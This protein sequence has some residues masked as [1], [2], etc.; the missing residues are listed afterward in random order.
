MSEHN[1]LLLY[2]HDT[3]PTYFIEILCFFNYLGR[4]SVLKKEI[5]SSSDQRGPPVLITYTSTILFSKLTKS[6]YLHIVHALF[7]VV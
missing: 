4:G 6:Y 2:W 3:C 1:L 7:F 5:L